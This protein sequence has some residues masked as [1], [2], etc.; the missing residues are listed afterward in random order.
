MP[1]LS[2]SWQHLLPPARSVI[3]VRALCWR[4]AATFVGHTKSIW[5]S[6]EVTSVLCVVP[7][8][9]SLLLSP[10]EAKWPRW[11]CAGVASGAG[12]RMLGLVIHR[13]QE[14]RTAT[15]P[16]GTSS[17]PGSWSS[18]SSWSSWDTAGTAAELGKVGEGGRAGRDSARRRS[19]CVGTLGC[20]SGSDPTSDLGDLLKRLKVIPVKPLWKAACWMSPVHCCSWPPPAPR[21]EFPPLCSQ[22]HF[23]PL[24]AEPTPHNLGCLFYSTALHLS[25]SICWCKRGFNYIISAFT[26]SKIFWKVQ[27]VRSFPHPCPSSGSCL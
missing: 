15:S 16:A 9:P 19:G 10:Q 7:R 17:S 11:V 27:P 2:F 18:W 21:Q 20:P 24:W 8:C 23:R 3:P 1:A 4:E 26:S 22:Q 6:R 25:S 5:S 14:T 13:G 12:Q